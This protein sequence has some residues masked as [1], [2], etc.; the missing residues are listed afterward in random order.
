MPG[1]FEFLFGSSDK[2]RKTPT[3]TG[4]QKNLLSQILSQVGGMGQVGGNYGLA[5]QRLQEQLMGGDQAYQ[6]FA[7]PYLRQFQEEIMPQ[8]A[9]RFAGG[10]FGRGGALSSSSFAQ[11]LGTAGAGLQERL[12]AL[13]ANQQQNAIGSTLGQYNT[14][15]G[16]GLSAKPFGTF[17]RGGNQGILPFLG[18]GLSSLTSGGYGGIAGLL[19]MGG[20]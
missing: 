19:G 4:D 7:A 9:E 6:A 8:I 18:A 15:A 17:T 13:G 11:A 10:G 5:Q 12:A 14:L 16:Y 20:H 1:I 3:M 2:L